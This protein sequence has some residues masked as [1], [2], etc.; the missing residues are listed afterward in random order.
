M[1]DTSQLPPEIRAAWDDALDAYYTREIPPVHWAIRLVAL[2]AI[3]VIPWGAII[4]G[5]HLIGLI[6]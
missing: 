5:L 2:I 3:I 6:A 1:T 4:Y